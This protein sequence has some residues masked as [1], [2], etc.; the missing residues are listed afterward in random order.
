MRGVKA[1]VAGAVCLGFILCLIAPMPTFAQQKQIVLKAS[2]N[3]PKNITVAVAYEAWLREI[4]KKTNGVVKPEFYWASSLLKVTETVKG[5]GAGIADVCFDV[6]G[7]HPS[8][9]PLSTIGDLGYITNHGD[10]AARALTELYH[11]YPAFQKEFDQHNLKVMFFVPFPP[12]IIGFVKPV[13]TLED[14]KGKKIRALGVLNE[15]VAKLGATPLGIP[16][17]DMYE[18]LSRKVIEGYTGFGI[19]GVK[20]FKLDE[21]CKNY[22][23]FGYGSYNVGIVFMNKDKWN[24]LPADVRKVIE[25]VNARAIDIYDDV[26]A[27]AEA[28]DVAPLKPAGCTFYTLPPDEMNRWKNLVVPAI[29][30]NWIEKQKAFGNTQEFFNQYLQLVKKFESQSKYANPFPR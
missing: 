14:L 12:N 4:E 23:D 8:E 15:V 17:N 19:S 5:T 28:P 27:K 3:A 16:L 10:T 9:T 26:F 24:S 13:R 20:G 18:A 22:V 25:E 1:V 29:W 6:P 21:V 7:Y 11:Q 30:N 2:H